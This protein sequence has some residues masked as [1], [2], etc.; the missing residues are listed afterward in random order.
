MSAAAQPRRCSL[1]PWR[2]IKSSESSWRIYDEQGN[3]V[4][5]LATT[6]V[7]DE[8][9]AY[10]ARLI[11]A[12]PELEEM[13]AACAGM[14][15]ACADSLRGHG[16]LGPESAQVLTDQYRQCMELLHRISQPTPRSP[17]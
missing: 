11:A 3:A 17:T 5:R 10:D 15:S 4:A 7:T 9:R 1:Y 12:A 16:R 6:A 2:A 14:L 13:L 8:R